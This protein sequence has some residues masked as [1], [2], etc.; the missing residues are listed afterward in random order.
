M[1]ILI[2]SYNYSPEPIGIAPLMTELAEGLVGRGHQVRVI[3]AMPNYPQR[4]I[5]PAYRHQFFCTEQVNGVLVQRSYLWVR[6]EPGLLDRILLDGS[7]VL[8]SIFQALRGWRPDIILYTTPPLPVSVPAACLGLL[9]N[10]PV[11]L[12]VQD[13]LPEAAVHVG[14]LR[15][16]VLIKVFKILEKFAYRTAT[17]ITVITDRFTENLVNKSVPPDKITCIPNWV[18][19]N[20]I[21]S[22]PK[23]ET[24]FRRQHQLQGKFIAL[25]SGNIALTQ[26]IETAIRAAI[27]LQ[28]I[29]DIVLVIVG[30]PRRL[31]ELQE[32]CDLW[33]ANN[34]KLLPFQAEA[35]LPDMLAA[36]DVGLVLQRHNVIAFNMPSK[37]QKILASGRPIIASVPLM[38]SAAEVVN[39]S[40]AGLV[41]PPEK[42]QALADAI[43]NLYH[44]PASASKLGE[45]GRQFAMNHYAY[46]QA[47][48]AY[49]DL[50]IAL[51]KHPHS[52]EKI[53]VDD[54]SQP[55]DQNPKSSIAL[56]FLNFI[57]SRLGLGNV[58]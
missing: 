56:Q 46:R 28:H 44:D 36:A 50:F 49:E 34:V 11:I 8:T 14:L 57:L 4:E 42:P 9:W 3:T 16:R 19:V 23:E 39:Q 32:K 58:T 22:F 30:E 31:A 47:L 7:F 55:E 37:I 18:D 48:Q 12:N 54:A 41:V 53:Q 51:L 52:L 21:R 43:L 45:K 38:G 1:K 13:I 5:Y 26:G 10:C 27:K 20:V 6:P 24:V 29:P 33:G 17:N 35:M 2:Y 25:Y 40:Q 15:N